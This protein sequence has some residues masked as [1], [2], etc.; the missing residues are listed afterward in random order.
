[1][2]FHLIINDISFNNYIQ[3]KIN[4]HTNEFINFN[5]E[6][7][8]LSS[9]MINKYITELKTTGRTIINYFTNKECITIKKFLYN[10]FKLYGHPNSD[11]KNI[12]YNNQTHGTYWC[13]DFNTIKENKIRELLKDEGILHIIQTYFNTTPKL[14]TIMNWK[15]KLSINS[16]K[17]KNQHAQQFHQDSTWVT[18][19]KIFIYLNDVTE[20][21][22][23]HRFIKNSFKNLPSELINTGYKPGN[24]LSDIEIKKYFGDNCIENIIG[25]AGTIIIEDT[26]NFHSGSPCIEGERDLYEITY[27][28][29]HYPQKDK[30][31]ENAS[32]L[33]KHLEPTFYN[34]YPNIFI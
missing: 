15:T 33:F 27:N 4:I 8:R 3:S 11:I 29:G 16:D 7:S 24:R 32:N 2:I 9:Q 19:I 12:P 20:K 1:M 14:V 5:L 23:C 10:N 26:R 28:A 18:F 25:N 31:T 17:Y 22:A 30:N 13:F 21:N 6:N 34:K